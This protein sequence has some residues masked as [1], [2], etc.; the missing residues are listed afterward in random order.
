MPRTSLVPCA[1]SVTAQATGATVGKPSPVSSRDA[2]LGIVAAQTLVAEW[3]AL[4]ADLVEA[5]K[6]HPRH[7]CWIC[8]TAPRQVVIPGSPV[9]VCKKC[10]TEMEA[11]CE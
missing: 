8:E 6:D 10:H 11:E 1:G 5:T 9:G 4:R 7:I 3:Q 2:A